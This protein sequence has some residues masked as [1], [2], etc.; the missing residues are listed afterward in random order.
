MPN[1]R[2]APH[3]L[4]ERNLRIV[5]HGGATS[6]VVCQHD[7]DRVYRILQERANR[8][9][10]AVMQGLTARWVRSRRWIDYASLRKVAG[11]RIEFQRLGA[12]DAGEDAEEAPVP[13]LDEVDQSC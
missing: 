1:C 6:T 5:G 8:P 12:R 11:H 10:I 9:N 2:R 13:R 7:V 3:E 4:R